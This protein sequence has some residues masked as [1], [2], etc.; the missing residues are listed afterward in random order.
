MFHIDGVLSGNKKN[1]TH[2]N[3]NKFI[4]LQA[5]RNMRVLSTYIL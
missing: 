2:K 3:I 4:P 5:K 1:N